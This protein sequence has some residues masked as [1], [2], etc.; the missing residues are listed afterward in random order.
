MPGPGSGPAWAGSGP[1]RLGP[2]LGL[3]LDPAQAWLKPR[4]GLGL[5]NTSNTYNKTLKP[6]FYKPH[7][8]HQ[9]HIKYIKNA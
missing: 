1:A 6:I 8:I 3:G 9:R 7:K 2:G 4:P 5:E